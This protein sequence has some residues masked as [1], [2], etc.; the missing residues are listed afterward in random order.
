MIDALLLALK[1]GVFGNAIFMLVWL[2][3][4]TTGSS[5]VAGWVLLDALI[6]VACLLVA[7]RYRDEGV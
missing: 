2:G 7:G 3:L 6:I 1:W 5:P 4:R